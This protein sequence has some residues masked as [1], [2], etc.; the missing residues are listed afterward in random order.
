MKT[1]V[2]IEGVLVESVDSINE[3]GVSLTPN[4]YSVDRSLKQLKIIQLLTP[5]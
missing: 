5:T 1:F 3:Q 2:N 4:F